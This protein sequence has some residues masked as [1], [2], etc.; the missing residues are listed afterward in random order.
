[1]KLIRPELVMASMLLLLVSC[2]VSQELENYKDLNPDNPDSGNEIDAIDIPNGF[3]FSTQKEIQVTINDSEDNVKYDVFAYSSEKQFARIE[4]YE[5]EEGEI[6]TDSVFNSG[7]LGSQLFN[8]VTKNGKLTHSV[9]LPNHFTQLYI[10]RKSKLKYTSKV[11]DVNSNQVNYYDASTNKVFGKNGNTQDFLYCV[12]G[13][14]ELFQIDP[15]SGAFTYLSDMPVGSYT[16]AIDQEHKVLYS[17]GR[18]NPHPLMKYSIVHNTWETITNFGMSG[19]RLDFNANDGLLY[20]SKGRNLYTVNPSNGSILNTWTINGLHTTGGGDIVFAEDGT[21]FLCSFSG[22]YRLELDQNN[23]YQSTRI[24]AANLPFKP[25]SMTFDSNGQLWLANKGNNSDLIT[26]DTETGDWQ[27]VYGVNAN[28]NTNFDRTINDLATFKVENTVESEPD[29]DGDGVIDS[30]DA[31]PNDADLAFEAF[32][33]S[34]FGWGT[35]A[36]EDLWPHTGD[37]DFNDVALKYRFKAVL[38]AQNQIVQLDFT[39]RVKAN[40]ASSVNGFGLEIESLV[41]NQIESVTGLDLKHAFINLNSNGTEAGQENAVFVMFDDARSMLN[42]TTTV[43]IIFAQPVHPN[44]IEP[45]PFNPFIIVNKERAK[46]VHLPFKNPTTLGENIINVSGVNRDQDGNYVTETGL[47]WAINVAYDFKVPNERVKIIEAYN[48]FS[49][50]ATSG[51]AS[52][53][54]WYEDNPGHI[55]NDKV[56]NE[57]F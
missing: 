19:P 42:K 27:Y 37:Y 49:N 7:V 8:G 3:K 6:L 41:P 4:T 12:N 10:R 29:S 16:C 57:T 30:N 39:Y 26:M 15:L 54:N 43:S 44:S 51:G 55:N 40:G 25:T 35:F 14:G 33:P 45:A 5:N 11:V 20:F 32:T 34:E 31:Y 23:V 48:F 52:F 22:L 9:I 53:D 21:L 28:N 36:F 2:D 17:I 24:S 46:E 13:S 38:N 1:M 50:W 47:P 56:K 18:C